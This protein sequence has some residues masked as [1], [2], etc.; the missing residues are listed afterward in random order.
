MTEVMEF[1]TVVPKK[2][3]DEEVNS[4]L[5]FDT[6]SDVLGT[7]LA[8]NTSAFEDVRKKLGAPS[9]MNFRLV[10]RNLDVTKKDDADNGGYTPIEGQKYNM[11][12]LVIPATDYL[13]FDDDALERVNNT[14][15]KVVRF[16]IIT[17]S[18]IYMFKSRSTAQNFI[19]QTHQMIFEDAA[20]NSKK[21]LDSGVRVLV[22]SSQETFLGDF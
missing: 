6:R 21:L 7:R 13:Q 2:L 16:S 20:A 18:L 3:K 19:Q 12:S 9:E 17:R 14:L 1:S 22:P 5:L 8:F 4:L 15:Y 11:W 10:L